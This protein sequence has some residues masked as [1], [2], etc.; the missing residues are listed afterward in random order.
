MLNRARDD[1]A[2]AAEL[3]RRADEALY[4]AK[5]RGR[6]CVF[7]ASGTLPAAPRG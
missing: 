2:H 1:D 4:E 7:R 6:N 5:A 3:V